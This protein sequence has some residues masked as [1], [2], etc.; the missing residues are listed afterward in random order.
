MDV[1]VLTIDKIGLSSRSRNTLYRAGIHTVGEMLTHT[2]QSL[3]EIRNLGVKSLEEILIKIEEY[4]KIDEGKRESLTEIPTQENLDAWILDVENQNKVKVYLEKEKTRIEV[5]EELSTRTF[6]LL[7]FA[8]YEYLHQVVF[9]SKENLMDISRMDTLSASEILESLKKY[10]LEIVTNKK[11]Y[12]NGDLNSNNRTKSIFEYLY[13]PE[14]HDI[15]YQYVKANDVETNNET[16]TSIGEIE[17]AKVTLPIS[18][19]LKQYTGEV[20]SNDS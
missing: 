16:D 17:N 13:L 2:E 12:I 9:L 8:G 3:L 1:K 20:I 14:Y 19:N 18:I 10:V 7:M 6:N 5:L 4:K 11:L 15:I